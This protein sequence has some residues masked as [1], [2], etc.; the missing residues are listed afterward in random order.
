MFFIGFW[1]PLC[2]K[3]HAKTP[4][5]RRQTARSLNS[6]AEHGR[7]ESENSRCAHGT[8]EPKP[9]GSHSMG[10]VGQ[11]GRGSI[12][13]GSLRCSGADACGLLARLRY[14]C[15]PTEHGLRPIQARI[16][17][18]LVHVEPV[19]STARQKKLQMGG[20]CRGTRRK[21]TDLTS[22]P[23]RRHKFIAF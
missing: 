11:G 20:R 5:T 22:K 19:H 2:H 21:S 8:C 15:G 7:T 13:C 10:A 4:R 18:Y 23:R 16:A 6:N 3:K 12:P 14:L 17:S 1:T 9:V